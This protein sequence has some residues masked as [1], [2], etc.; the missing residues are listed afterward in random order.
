MANFFKENTKKQVNK[1]LKKTTQT[2]TVIIDRL[3]L[4]G[5]GVGRYQQKPIFVTGSL[6]SETVEIRIIEQKNKYILAKLLNVNKASEHRIDAQCQHFSLCG[7]C[8]LQ[9]LDYAEQLL[10]KQKKV[11]ELLSRSGISSELI[12]QLPWQKPIKSSQWHYRRKARIGVQFDKNSQAIIGFRQKA[13]NQLVSIKSCPVLVKPAA[14]IFQILKVLLAKLTV[15]KAIGHIEVISADVVND[16]NNN[17]TLVVRQIRTINAHD[18]QLW[19]EY[20]E[21]YCW[22]V[23]FLESK[24]GQE[25][26]GEQSNTSASE[27]SYGELSYQL[28][29]DIDIYFSNTDFIQI[30]QSVNLA[31]IEQALAW[32]MPEPND[33]VLDLFCGL[34]NFSLPL[35]KKVTKVVGVE[36]IQTMVDKALTNA[37]INKIDNCQFYQADLNSQWLSSSWAKNNFTKVLLDPARAGAEQAVEQV[38]QL[39]IAIILYVSCDPTTLARDSKILL[40]KGYKIVKIGLIDMFSQTKHVETMVLFQR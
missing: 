19:Q 33:Q 16:K 37:K 7:G 26:R 31:M 30:N 15:K 5:C 23:Q 34:G 11:A 3:D 35:A 29:D 14:D 27:L 9:H 25:S 6:P 17:L 21:K 24:K 20:A 38:S 2:N 28:H 12:N 39:N 8:D 4:N 40:D 13:T 10:F 32:L 1:K 22:T 18:R 36:G